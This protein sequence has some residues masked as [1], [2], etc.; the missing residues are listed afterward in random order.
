MRAL[1]PYLAL[2]KRH[3]WLLMLGV[4][5]AIVTLLASIGLLTLSGWFLS[6]SA[7]V[8][9]AGIYS[10]NYMLPAAGVRGAAIIRT[11]GRYFERLVSHDATFRVLQHLRVFTF[12]K[13]LPLSPAGLARF[14][15]G[16]LL[17]RIV[18]D[19]D[20]LDHLYLRVISPLVGALVVILVVT[21]GLSIL[22]VTLALTLGGIM[23]L[24]VL[25]LPPLFYRA[26]K[27]AGECITQ[28]RGQYRQQLTAWLQGQAEL[29]LFNASDRYREQLEKTEQRWQ[30]GQR[31]QAELTALSQAL[32]LLIGGVAVIAMLWLTSAGVGGNSQPGALIALFVFCALAAFEALA[33][34]TGAFQ[35]LG[36]V[37][38]SARRITQITEQPPEV[39]FAQSADQTFSR[40]ALTLNQV[41]FSYPQQPTAALENI[42][43]QVSAGDHI[44]ILGRTGCGKSTLLQLL[45]RAW[46]PAQGE[47]LLNDQPLA[48]LNET[49]L[50]RA[51]SV[52]PQRVHLFS[53]TLRDNLLLAAPQASDA[54]LVNILERV[55]LG[56]LLDDSGLNSWLGEG[57]RQ[58]SGGELR[59]LAIARALLHDAPLMLLDEPT[60]GLDA[61]T[62]SQ[63]LDLLAEVMKEKTVL[64]VTHRLRGLA[65][66]NQIIIMDNGKIIEQG[67]HAEL[68]A[69]QGRYYQFKQRL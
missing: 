35:H 34:V 44:A 58:L 21:A 40:V 47:I 61:T 7:V 69:Q 24:T 23:L 17:N 68:L 48:Q 12:S 3:I 52:V 5:L 59:R 1:L 15:Q 55:G 28:M 41:T 27:P 60:E 30:D 22:D 43:L 51:M 36:Q 4:V 18:A 65:R 6:A 19:V 10:F 9:V 26:G 49:T 54:H 20:T 14:R 37:I 29:M 45:T 8:G 42:S 57:G 16:E 2:Y 63:I 33:P 46:D 25:I 50:R 53:A 31:R 39:S 62:E 32:M 64:M 11:A 38:A 66:F 13:L 67:S 56:K